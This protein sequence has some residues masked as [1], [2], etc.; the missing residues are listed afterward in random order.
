[1]ASTAASRSSPVVTSNRSGWASSSWSWTI[2]ACCSGPAI[3]IGIDLGTEVTV[4]QEK[5]RTVIEMIT[6]DISAVMR[7]LGHGVTGLALS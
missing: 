7:T 2:S 5:A 4:G 3:I 1:M 6:A